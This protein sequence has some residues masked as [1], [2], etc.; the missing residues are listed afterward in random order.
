M[1]KS[2]RILGKNNIVEINKSCFGRIK[3]GKKSQKMFARKV[4]FVDKK[5]KKTLI[6][7]I[8]VNQNFFL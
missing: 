6:L 1:G 4:E 7:I 2:I 5:N 3:Y 8:R